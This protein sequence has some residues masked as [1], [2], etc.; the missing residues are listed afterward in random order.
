[1]TAR[2]YLSRIAQPLIAGDP[3]VWSTPRAAAEDARPTATST[4]TATVQR[5]TAN[6]PAGQAT[7]R[8]NPIAPA[9]PASPLA[10][11]AAPLTP[12]GVAN[13][14]AEPA[15]EPASTHLEPAPT[16]SRSSLSED[17]MGNEPGPTQTTTLTPEAGATFELGAFQ[18]V[19][20][21]SAPERQVAPPPARRVEPAA[22]TAP[23]S[24]TPTEIAPASASERAKPAPKTDAPRLHIGT[25]EVRTSAPAP[26]AA[27]MTAVAPAAPSARPASAPIGRGYASRFGLVQG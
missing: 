20:A 10:I 9:A 2:S 13:T 7:A 1:M 21:E 16:A 24:L 23:S 15:V 26:I 11:D 8:P 3:V 17:R 19:H 27:P 5:K 4:T 12:P 18:P 14:R 25:I 22:A 6:P